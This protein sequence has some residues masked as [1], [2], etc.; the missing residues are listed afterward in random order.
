MGCASSRT[1]IRIGIL[2][3]DQPYPQGEHATQNELADCYRLASYQPLRFLDT[4]E[5]DWAREAPTYMRPPSPPPYT[6]VPLEGHITLIHGHSP[7][8]RHSSTEAGTGVRAS[9]DGS[10]GGDL[11][12]AARELVGTSSAQQRSDE[13]EIAGNEDD[14]PAMLTAASSPPERAAE[15]L[16]PALGED[17]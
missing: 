17:V 1:P 8:K 16:A 10:Y 6:P 9:F 14:T 15:Q 3:D 11:E 5:E 4:L 2:E 7:E 12:A 13:P